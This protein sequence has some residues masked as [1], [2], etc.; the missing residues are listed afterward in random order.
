MRE[1]P[2]EN[3]AVA[4]PWTGSMKPQDAANRR[5]RHPICAFLAR[6][7]H[8]LR[9]MDIRDQL[10]AA[11][12]SPTPTPLIASTALTSKV[13]V[14]AVLV[15]DESR[16]PLGNFKVLGG[17]RA[18][19]NA[20]ARH[21]G[22]SVDALASRP[23]SNLPPLVCASDG[24]HGLAVA[25]AAQLAGG[26]AIIVLHRQV[27]RQR[28]ARIAATGAE[29]VTV[30][31]TY[32]D[33][34]DRAAALAI[35][36][37]GLLIADTSDRL[38]DPIVADVMA[39]YRRVSDEIV[40]QL[41]A[42]KAAPPTHI[43][44]QA[45]VGGLAAALAEG[46]GSTIRAPGRIVVVEPERAA[47]VAHALRTG[48]AE[49]VPGSLD[50]AA[51]MLS[52]GIAS[53]PAVRILRRYRAV[54]ITIGEAALAAGEKALREECAIASTSSGAAGLAGLL[55]IA[56]DRVARMDLSLGRDSRVLVVATEA[57]P[58]ARSGGGGA[59]LTAAPPAA[60][61]P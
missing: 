28:A 6:P 38:D 55:A 54:P 47:C 39:G 2:P 43:F 57:D 49:R 27:D 29:I 31:G 12:R 11:L 46:L 53:A 61:R 37:Q 23:I 4:A 22:L 18:G 25:A 21:A 26:P 52:C 10:L 3:G 41:Q 24:N 20:L 51:E 35:A 32:D 40:V 56:S 33:A 34:V 16:R 45:G 17:L 60:H 14:A 58:G 48:V 30:E 9:R 7:A 44:V 15:K 5:S 8:I 50:T 36:T 19:L 59:A 1:R 42:L 13:G